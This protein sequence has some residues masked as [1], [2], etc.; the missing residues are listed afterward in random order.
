MFVKFPLN[1]VIILSIA[2]FFCGCNPFNRIRLNPLDPLAVEQV[3]IDL[4]AINDNNTLGSIEISNE[5]S[6]KIVL[7]QSFVPGVDIIKKIGINLSA[8]EETIL[9]A[10]LKTSYNNIPSDTE[11]DH[12]A[13][14]YK[15]SFSRGESTFTF[16]DLIY[17][18][19]GTEYWI[20][21]YA[22]MGSARIYLYYQD[23]YNEGKMLKKDDVTDWTA[24]DNNDI[25]I[26][27]YY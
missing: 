24:H 22:L 6:N 19:P 5:E 10:E 26:A 17:V 1:K 21:I 20:V 11:I 25:Q 4:L 23:P 3:D 13:N 9:I 18:D 7:A 12:C 2:I 27:T 15:N 14:Y 8:T 16:D